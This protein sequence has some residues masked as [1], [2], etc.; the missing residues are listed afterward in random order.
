MPLSPPV[1]IR[2]CFFAVSTMATALSTAAWTTSKRPAARPSRWAVEFSVKESSSV[3]PRLAK[4]PLAM[5]ACR[6]SAL[7]FGK[8]LT[9]TIAGS[10]VAGADAT[11]AR[12]RIHRCII[13]PLPSSPWICRNMR[14]ILLFTAGAGVNPAGPMGELQHACSRKGQ[15]LLATRVH[16]LLENQGV[17]HQERRG[18]RVDQRAR[19]SGRD[20]G[21]AQARRAQRSG[22]GARRQ[23]RVR[24][25][26]RRRHQVPRPEGADAGTAEP[27]RAGEEARARAARR[28]PLRPADPG[29]VA[30]Q[31]LSQ[32]QPADPRAVPPRVPDRRGISRIDARR[33]RADLRADHAGGAGAALGRGHRALRRERPRATAG[34]VENLSG[35]QLL[36]HDGHLLRQASPARGAGAHR[37]ASGAAHAPA[38]A[39]SRHIEYRAGSKAQRGGPRRAAAS[40]QGLGRR[41]GGGITAGGVRPRRRSRRLRRAR[42]SAPAAPPGSR[43]SPPRISPPAPA[44][45]CRESR[46]GSPSCR[47]ASVAQAAAAESSLAR[48]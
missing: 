28:V 33:P 35:P 13:C 48:P 29:G 16:E 36:A 38:D 12:T 43:A 22:G 47:R 8:L 4:M 15:S 41:K 17:P 20:G 30:R 9:R 6:G 14:V 23:V 32:S 1:T 10:A 21:A 44:V 46:W 24:A 7:A 39:D 3:T 26:A 37:L 18:L 19:Q 27:R 34:M 40:G 42:K 2:T 11:I 31:A 45:A 5:P 25:G